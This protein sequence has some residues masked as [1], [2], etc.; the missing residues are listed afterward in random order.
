MSIFCFFILYIFYF[1]FLSICLFPFFCN[2]YS[3]IMQNRISNIDYLPELWYTIYIDM[4]RRS[5]L[6]QTKCQKGAVPFIHYSPE[7]KL[8]GYYKEFTKSGN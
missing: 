8:P 3:P 4:L 7:H 6:V 2:I 1:L 5:L